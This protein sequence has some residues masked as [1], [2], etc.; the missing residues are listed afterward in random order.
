MKTK[1]FFLFVTIVITLTHSI[2]ICDQIITFFMKPF[3]T[4]PGLKD[5]NKTL[6]KIKRPGKLAQ[7][8][9]RAM[10]NE[11]EPSGIFCTYDGYLTASDLNG[12]VI[13]PR[14]HKDPAINLL[15]TNKMVP[16]FMLGNTIHHW[17]IEQ[18]TPAQ[19]Y[20]VK[21]NLD[22]SV[23][24]YFWDVQEVELPKDRRITLDTIVIM[25]KPKYFYVPTGISM[26]TSNPQLRLP[27]IYVK[28][29]IF[30]EPASLYMLTIKNFFQPRAFKYKKEKI[31]YQQLLDLR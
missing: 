29:G 24:A 22:R 19:M 27:N 18:G 17:E 15:I 28:K 3:P 6:Q 16:I 7:Y 1:K 10:L 9:L 11:Y 8:I 26:A 13:F 5:K 23:S 25:A 2:L 12:Q 30:K 4:I 31:K 14:R 20:V 21:R